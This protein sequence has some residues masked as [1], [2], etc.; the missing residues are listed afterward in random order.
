MGTADDGGRKRRKRAGEAEL[1]G[2]AP[3]SAILQQR[4]TTKKGER[5]ESRQKDE[6]QQPS[7][8]SRP[9]LGEFVDGVEEA[10]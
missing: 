1:D 9:R 2:I 6:G 8:W 4:T 7:K 3:P 5:Q 10:S